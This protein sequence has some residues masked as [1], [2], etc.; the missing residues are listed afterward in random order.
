[1]THV[2]ICDVT[3]LLS[4]LSQQP[5][6]VSSDESDDDSSYT[7]TDDAPV[8]ARDAPAS[9][10]GGAVT[11]AA[12]ASSR[13]APRSTAVARPAAAAAAAAA[14]RKALRE[15]LHA[16]ATA[17]PARA[18]TVSK[19]PTAGVSLGALLKEASQAAAAAEEDAGDVGSGCGG[20][21][22]HGLTLCCTIRRRTS[23]FPCGF[24]TRISCSDPAFTS[25]HP[26][27]QQCT[28][29]CFKARPQIPDAHAELLDL[30][31]R[32]VLGSLLHPQPVLDDCQRMHALLRPWRSTRTQSPSRK[33][34]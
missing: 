19:A 17:K 29:Y 14:G 10:R 18:T 2:D 34:G 22:L 1:M 27:W 32:L 28:C 21:I 30:P 26:H 25:M 33:A 11:T 8:S 3:L 31:G 4:S 15:A 23:L 13:A 12:A 7:D 9:A 24:T 5:Q 6:A 16:Q 20:D